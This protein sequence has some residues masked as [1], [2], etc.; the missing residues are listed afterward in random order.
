[1]F[2]LEVQ[3]WDPHLSY[4]RSPHRYH[5]WA[6]AS[7]ARGNTWMVVR[8][9]MLYNWSANFISS[10]W[11]TPVTWYRVPF[12]TQT[13]IG[14]KNKMWS[15]FFNVIGFL[16]LLT[17]L[18]LYTYIL[19]IFHRYF[20]MYSLQVYVGQHSPD[21]TEFITC[22]KPRGQ[23]IVVMTHWLVSHSAREKEALCINVKWLLPSLQHSAGLYEQKPL[24]ISVIGIWCV[25]FLYDL[26][27]DM[28]G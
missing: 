11:M 17:Y 12:C 24:I 15:I 10:S 7:P 21:W 16:I 8:I 23:P 22:V 2:G 5:H 6:W 13:F 25:R 28:S 26:H 20:N 3:Y 27:S 4:I 1:M 19:Y 14:S 9:I 18:S